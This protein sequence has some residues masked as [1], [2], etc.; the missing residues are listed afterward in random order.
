MKQSK[1]LVIEIGGF[2]KSGLSDKF[3]NPRFIGVVSSIPGEYRILPEISIKVCPIINK[4]HLPSMQKLI[5]REEGYR[6]RTI[7]V[8]HNAT[9]PVIQDLNS[10]ECLTFRVRR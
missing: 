2:F 1:E 8:H 3:P 6:R 4:A 7:L 10:A 5:F 9:N